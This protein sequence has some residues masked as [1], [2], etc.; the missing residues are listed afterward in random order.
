MPLSIFKRSSE[1]AKWQK[2]KLEFMN[3]CGEGN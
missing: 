3:R 1:Y 2:I